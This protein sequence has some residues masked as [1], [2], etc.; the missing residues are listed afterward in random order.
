MT[1][2]EAGSAFNVFAGHVLG[3][4]RDANTQ[5]A[6]S[7]FSGIAGGYNTS[8]ITTALSY[9]AAAVAMTPLAPDIENQVYQSLVG[10]TIPQ[11]WS[12][13]G[14]DGGNYPFI[15]YVDVSSYV[16]SPSFLPYQSTAN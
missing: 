7:L 9:G 3:V 2:A 11:A 6:V 13:N 10:L 4:M 12:L 1:A 8:D 16:S 14:D 5:A 15:M